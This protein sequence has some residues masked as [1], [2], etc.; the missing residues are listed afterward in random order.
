MADEK[1]EKTCA[2]P[3]CDCP[4]LKGEKYCSPHCETAPEEVICGCGHEG[5]STAGAEGAQVV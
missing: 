4:A 3:G 1:H 5:C 2:H